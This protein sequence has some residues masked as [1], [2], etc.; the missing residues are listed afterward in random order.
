MQKNTL[1]R[2][3]IAFTV[4]ALFIGAGVVPSI[5]GVGGNNYRLFEN[6][7]NYTLDD[8]ASIDEG[9]EYWALLVAVG[10]YAGHPDQDRPSMLR[11]VENLHDMLLVSEH[12]KEDHISC[13]IGENATVRNI[14][15]GLRWLDKMDDK[16]DFSLVYITT[17]GYPLRFDIPPF[18]EDDR[19]D[20][21]L[22]SYKGFKHPWK[23]IWDDLLNLL[24][25]LLNSKGVCVIVDTCY[26]GGFN[27]PPY[28]TNFMKNNRMKADE[29][30]QEFAE[31]LS[32]SGRVVLM[33]C[34]EDEVSYSSVFTPVLIEGFRGYADTNEDGIVSVEE[35]FVYAEENIDP[36][37]NMH[38]TIYDGY[39]GELQLTEVELP[40]S[41]PETPIGQIIG[42]TNTTY[43]Y[44]TI[45]VDPEDDRI[46]YGWDWDSDNIVD[47]WTDLVDSGTWVNVSLSWSIE[48]TYNIKVKAVDELGVESEW[49][50]QTVVSMCSD[51]VPD[52]RQTEML[53]GIF[54]TMWVAQSFIPSL[55][56]LSKVELGIESW[57]SGNPLPIPLYIRDNLTGENLAEISVIVPPNGYDKAVWATFDF[58]DL[59]VIPGNTYYIV[60]KEVGGAWG[61]C[62][63]GA[64]SDSYSSGSFF[65]SND[66]NSWRSY[67]G[68]GCFVTWS[69]I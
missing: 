5:V 19:R 26:A 65:T 57:G 42:D 9:T 23:I 20:E 14:I 48:G 31:D 50:N 58:E 60:C 30:M 37:T 68:D 66:G 55:S 53:G 10:V 18:D 61:Y 44:S 36:W 33:S 40:P 17:H 22:I 49:S 32:G 1:S 54:L 3:G 35:A 69:K 11:D 16:D 4:I 27:D 29:W 38:P 63:S 56:P 39:P 59:D 13:I 7:T 62:W 15:K 45:S 28:F 6:K 52:Q 24:L 25:S 51:H 12:W 67:P 8:A 64:G 21:A 46:R 2:K 41:V 34:R 47:E 43:N